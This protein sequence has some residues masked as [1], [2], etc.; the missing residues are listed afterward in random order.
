MALTACWWGER[1][2]AGKRHRRSA[3]EG[4]IQGAVAFIIDNDAGL[5]IISDLMRSQTQTVFTTSNSSASG[6]VVIITDSND[7]DGGTLSINA[8]DTSSGSALTGVTLQAPAESTVVSPTST[9]VQSLSA[10]GTPAADVASTL[11]LDWR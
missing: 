9:I 4:P 10:Q 2:S 11:R 3:N 8:V 6:T 1:F 7:V 5:N